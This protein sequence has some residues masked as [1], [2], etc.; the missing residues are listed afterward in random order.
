MRLALI[1]LA[2]VP[3]LA[4]ACS[5]DDGTGDDTQTVNCAE[6]T[7][8]EDFVAGLEKAGQAG[9]L[10]FK[11]LTADPAPPAR[12]DNTWVVQVN[13]MSNGIVGA[14]V[15]GASMAVTPYMPDH[16]HVSPKTVTLQPVAGADGQYT[17]T[18]IYFGMPGYWETTLDVTTPS[19][20]DTVVFKFCIPS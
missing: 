13:A 12:F 1:A 19:G 4:A 20:N 9:A 17:L 8:D 18:P 6:E 15:N 16:G 5:G 3:S 10:D 14:P 11:L 2:T 7:R